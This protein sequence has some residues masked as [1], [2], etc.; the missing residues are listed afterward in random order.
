MLQLFFIRHAQSENNALWVNTGSDQNRVEDP[1]LT[2]VGLQ[3]AS[4]LAK[5][6]REGDPKDNNPPT[7]HRGFGLTHLYSS[8]MVRAVQTGAMIAEA[9]GLPHHAWEDVHEMGGIFLQDVETGEYT[10]LPGKNRAYF[11]ERFPGLILSETVPDAG[12]WNHRPREEREESFRRAD[13]FLKNLRARHGGT[14]DRVAVVSH[15]GFYNDF[16]LAVLGLPIQNHLWF[17]MYNTAITRIDF[18]EDTTEV[19]YQNRVDH[20]PPDL[21]T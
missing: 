5:F 6:L 3:Q 4:L 15:G 18:H 13:G 2:E 19:V 9:T 7:T 12:W 14:N 11:K 1:E 10:R 21:I 8:L 17:S 20:L 16:L